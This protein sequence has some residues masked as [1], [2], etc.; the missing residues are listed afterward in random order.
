METPLAP[1]HTLGRIYGTDWTIA[2][3]AKLLRFNAAQGSLRAGSLTGVMREVNQA[4][5]RTTSARHLPS[6]VAVAL[7]R[8]AAGNYQAE[9][10]FA[11]L[12]HYLT[13]NQSVAEEWLAALFLE[14]RPRVREDISAATR[15]AACRLFT[16]AV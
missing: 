11:G 3:V 12:D 14:H 1:R 7:Q 16:L 10:C 2:N 8:D 5:L 4:Y 9:I 15:T 13:W 6:G